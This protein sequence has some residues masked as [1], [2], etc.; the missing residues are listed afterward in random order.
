MTTAVRGRPARTKKSR[1]KNAESKE[2][3]TSFR[4]LSD[5]FLDC[6]DPGLRHKWDRVND[7]HV[8]EQY[9]EGGVQVMYL[10]RTEECERCGTIKEERFVNTRDGGVE[11]I[12]QTYTYPEGYSM[13]GVPRGVKPSVIVYQEQ[14]RRAMERVAGAKPGEREVSER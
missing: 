4:G 12:G 11:K 9:R 13:P 8:T 10:A 7:L 14:W 6:R 3:A 2:M 1:A 5:K